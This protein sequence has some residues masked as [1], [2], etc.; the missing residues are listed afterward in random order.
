MTISRNTRSLSPPTM[1]KST[2]RTT[3]PPSPVNASDFPT[4]GWISNTRSSTCGVSDRVGTIIGYEDYYIHDERVLC[5]RAFSIAAVSTT[6]DDGASPPGSTELDDES[7]HNCRMS[8]ETY[9][10]FAQLVLGLNHNTWTLDRTE[11]AFRNLIIQDID[12]VMYY[13]DTDNYIN[14]VP[15]SFRDDKWDIARTL[16]RLTLLLTGAD[17]CT[18]HIINS[19]WGADENAC[20]TLGGPRG[21]LSLTR[22]KILTL[23]KVAMNMIH[24]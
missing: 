15:I 1:P 14:G 13:W 18:P 12:T 7:G 10:S 5:T 21:D 6:I 11:R 2:T 16:A 9:K 20:I 4:T 3:K 8:A 24:I 19:V 22:R 17:A 23:S